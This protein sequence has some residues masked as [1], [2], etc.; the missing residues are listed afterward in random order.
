MPGNVNMSEA[1]ILGKAEGILGSTGVTFFLYTCDYVESYCKSVD[2]AQATKQQ[3]W[4][5]SDIAECQGFLHVAFVGYKSVKML[6]QLFCYHTI[7]GY[8][9]WLG[10]FEPARMI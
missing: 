5:S 2:S 1:R 7:V 4:L 10:H 6:E 9:R 3:L 8:C